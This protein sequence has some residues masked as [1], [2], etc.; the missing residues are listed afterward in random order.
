MRQILSKKRRIEDMGFR[1]LSTEIH[2][3]GAT[4][5]TGVQKWMHKEEQY[6]KIAGMKMK[7]KKFSPKLYEA[8]MKKSKLKENKKAAEL[9]ESGVV[10]GATYGRRKG[11]GEREGGFSKTNQKMS[12]NHGPAPSNGFMKGGVLRLTKNPK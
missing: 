10:T 6:E 8:I 12:R 5:F 7:K 1:E 2:N 4:T 3:L 9:K 11:K